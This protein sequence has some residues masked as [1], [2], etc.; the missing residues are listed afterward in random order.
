MPH[1][2]VYIFQIKH[3]EFASLKR[4]SVM[5][6][7]LMGLVTRA[8]PL[9]ALDEATSPAP[10]VPG[11]RAQAPSNV[12]PADAAYSMM[13]IPPRPRA[14]P[15]LP[16]SVQTLLLRCKPSTLQ[17]TCTVFIASN[18]SSYPTHSLYRSSPACSMFDMQRSFRHL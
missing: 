15:P 7:D 18:R 5:M 2:V 16:G 12:A 1:G 6:R 14:P 3:H 10:A 11:P 4:I 9:V 17:L 13:I 8:L